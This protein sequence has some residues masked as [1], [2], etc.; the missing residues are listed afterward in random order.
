MG[1]FQ[2]IC[3]AISGF[4]MIAPSFQADLVALAIAAPALII[5]FVIPFMQNKQIPNPDS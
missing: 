1:A 3:L 2:R 4:V 5:Q